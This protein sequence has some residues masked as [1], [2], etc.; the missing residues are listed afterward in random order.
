MASQKGTSIRKLPS[1]DFGEDLAFFLY[2]TPIIASVVYGVYEWALI[3]HASGEMPGRA[4]LI[5]SKSPYLFLLSVVAICVAFAFETRAAEP[6]ERGVIV[7]SN[8]KR[9][10]FLSIVVLIISFAAAL[11]VSSY[12]ATNAA[13]VFIAGRYAIIYAF[14]LIGI[15][16]LLSYQELFGNFKQN[17]LP[18]VVGL[19]LLAASPFIF[20][21]GVR[22]HLPFAASSGAAIVFAII[23]IV[24]LLRATFATRKDS[25]Q[26]TSQSTQPMAKQ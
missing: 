9:L 14:F 2:L 11:S 25:P 16:L 21:G 1:K 26:K 10:Q 24:L 3:G 20:Y 18:E 5:V 19:I 12:D 8:V 15:S 23:G 7:K 4:Y 13:S 17:S 6:I 22:L